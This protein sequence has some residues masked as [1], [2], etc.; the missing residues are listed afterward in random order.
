MRGLRG[1]SALA[2]A[3]GVMASGAAHAQDGNVQLALVEPDITVTAI[4][5]AQDTFDV[6]TTVTV[7]DAEEIEENLAIDIKDLIRF[8]PGVS[9]ATSPSRFG[10]SLG[11][12]G[13]DGNSSF[14]IRGLGGNRVLFQIDSVRIPDGFSFGPNAFGRGDYVDLDLLQSIEIVRG[15][16]S[17]LYGSDGLAGVVSF[18]TKDP[19]DFLYEDEPLAARGRVSYAS[20]DDSWA[21]SL[22]AAGRLN[23]QWSA[24][25]AYTRRDGHETENQGELGGTGANRTQP[26]PQDIGSNAV[27]GRVV[28]QPSDQHRFRL[29]ADYGDRNIDTVSLTGLSASVID[30]YGADES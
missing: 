2:L 15:P 23:E 11:A 6:P 3:L 1:T 17:G 27:L 12:G 16:G 5:T 9:V 10:A 20:A 25:V 21:E 13:R 4:R 22:T 7:I 24:L 18:I 8:E 19:E 29:T 28:F 14:N 26:N 30:L